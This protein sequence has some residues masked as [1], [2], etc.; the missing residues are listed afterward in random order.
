MATLVFIE[1]V[2]QPGKS[3]EL[4]A[5]FKRNFHHSEGRDGF[6]HAAAY[7]SEDRDT[8]VVTQLW[9]SKTDFEQYLAW[10]ETAGGVAEFQ[11]LIA[12]EPV[13][14]FFEEG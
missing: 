8:V 2:P 12:Q 5:F 9:D 13:V 6:H 10:R 1:A 14:R 3:D 7:V 4:V 11:V